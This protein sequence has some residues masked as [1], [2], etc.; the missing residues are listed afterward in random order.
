M[1]TW[2][3]TLAGGLVAAVM[4]LGYAQSGGLTLPST[5]QA[6]T[7]FSIQT[8]GSGK[9]V[10]YIAGLG[11]ALKRDVQRGQTVRFAGGELDNAGHYLVSLVGDSSTESG[12]FDVVPAGQPAALSFL[13]RP[14]RLSVDLHDGISGAVYVFDAYHNLMTTPM[15]VS[16][17]LSVTSG[18][19]QARTVT[20]QDGAAWT[21]MDSSAKEGEA[22]F[23]ARAG[24]VSSTRVIQQVPGDPCS[25]KMTAQKEG[26]SIQLQTEPVVDCSGNAVPDGTVVTFTEMY[27]GMQT[28]VD[29]PLKHGIARAEV[30]DIDGARISA[31]TGVVLGNEISLGK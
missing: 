2:A 16:F 22:K 29:V 8:S 20:T 31:A 14:S 9:A 24:D 5:V 15:P 4:P 7:A 6:G 1:K 30:P 17:Q 10:L 3:K 19:T 12:A 11:G 27:H 21:Q 13:A 18:P 25:L 28:T 26:T 23:V